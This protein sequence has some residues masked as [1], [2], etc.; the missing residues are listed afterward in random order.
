MGPYLTQYTKTNSKWNKN[1]NVR[2]KSIKV[3]EEN[4]KAHEIEFGNDFSDIT[5][6]AQATKTKIDKCTTLNL[7]TF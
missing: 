6:K 2:P 3:P 1:L 7:K 4:G 5:P